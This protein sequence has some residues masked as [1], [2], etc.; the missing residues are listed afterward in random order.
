MN[1]ATEVDVYLDEYCKNVDVCENQFT[2]YVVGAM[3]DSNT[4]TS[5]QCSVCD[6]VNEY[7]GYG[8]EDLRNG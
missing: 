5:W 7:E 4:Y 3:T 8:W 1:Y 6:Y 2:G